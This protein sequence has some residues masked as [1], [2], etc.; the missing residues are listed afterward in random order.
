MVIIW[1]K[2]ECLV[3]KEEPDDLTHLAPT[4]GDSCIPLEVPTTFALDE[5]FDSA[6]LSSDI[7]DCFPLTGFEFSLGSMPYNDLADM[8]PG[9]AVPIVHSSTSSALRD[10]HFLFVGQDA[11]QMQPRFGTT[12]GSVSDASSPHSRVKL[13]DFVLLWLFL[14]ICSFILIL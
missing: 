3:L 1:L 5:L 4:A 7:L 8:D 6:D 2:L 13:A 14:F 9:D 11:N 12:G 10:N